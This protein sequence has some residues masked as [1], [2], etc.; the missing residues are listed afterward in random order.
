MITFL[1]DD[2]ASGH[3][4][5]VHQVDRINDY[6]QSCDDRSKLILQVW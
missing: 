4:V 1:H 6:L 2:K 5:A 3:V